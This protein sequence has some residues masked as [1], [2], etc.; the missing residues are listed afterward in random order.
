MFKSSTFSNLYKSIFLYS[1]IAM[2]QSFN[3]SVVMPI[4]DL[5]FHSS[6]FYGLDVLEQMDLSPCMTNQLEFLQIKQPLIV[7]VIISLIFLKT[8]QRLMLK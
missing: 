6:T 2:G 1:S 4:P 8:I 5:S 3:H 7:R